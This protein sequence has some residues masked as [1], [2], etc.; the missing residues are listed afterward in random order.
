MAKL[1]P[2]LSFPGTTREAMEFYRDVFG[3]ELTINTFR[4]VMGSDD[5]NA[6]RVMH[7][8]LET[9]AGFTLMAAD[10]AAETTTGNMSVIVSGSEAD[11]LRGYW[12]R[13]GEGATIGT[14]LEKQVWGD[15]YG[16]LVDRYGVPWGFDIDVSGED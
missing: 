4:E 9:P 8:E 15:E 16:D 1:N 10:M 14:P 3:G 5:P 11:E 13:L 12:A 2:Y 6:D 7:S